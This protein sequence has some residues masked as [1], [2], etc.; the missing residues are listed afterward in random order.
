MDTPMNNRFSDGMA[1]FARQD[2]S[3]CIEHL[4]EVLQ[5]NHTHKLA[6]VSRGAAFMRT[7]EITTALADF[8]HALAIDPD[9]ARAYHLRGLAR[10][11]QGDDEGALVDFSKAVD[12]KPDYAAA[13]YSRATLYTKLEQMD[14]AEEDSRMATHLS[15][16]N[17]QTFANEN[18][19]WRSDHMPVED[20]METELNR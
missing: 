7:G 15:E 12:L 11:A 2:Y 3:L 4:T 10:E 17:I 14:R 9:Y 8:D 6:L 16:Y 1:A 13:Y 19:I 20:M 5:E 18:N